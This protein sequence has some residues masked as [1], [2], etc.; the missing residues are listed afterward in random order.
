MPDEA[1]TA[2]LL[3]LLLLTHSRRAARTTA[4][5]SLVLLTHQDRSLWDQPLVEEGQALVRAC[6]R[7]AMPG[8]YQI[9]AA[10]N[11]VHS[12][13]A[14]DALTLPGL[15]EFVGIFGHRARH[16]PWPTHFGR[17]D[18]PKKRRHTGA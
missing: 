5:G 15:T 10:I 16:R 18:A 17:W 14:S 6:L 4:D 12:D 7:R 8:P 3:A 9:Q 1:E 13:T 2:G 11:A